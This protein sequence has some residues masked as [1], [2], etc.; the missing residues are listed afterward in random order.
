MKGMTLP[1]AGSLSSLHAWFWLHI[2]YKVP[3]SFL[4][5]VPNGLVRHLDPHPLQAQ[6]ERVRFEWEH[7]PIT[8]RRL[9]PHEIISTMNS[10]SVRLVIAEIIISRERSQH[11]LLKG[12]SSGIELM[13]CKC[14]W[15]C[16]ERRLTLIHNQNKKW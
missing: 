4:T 10:G 8:V 6:M 12:R 2:G 5:D 11:F 9:L 13:L 14:T 16:A 7:F 15:V 1:K 3:K